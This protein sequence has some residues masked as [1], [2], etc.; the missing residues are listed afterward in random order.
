MMSEEEE[1]M[2]LEQ[3]WRQP[4]N[5]QQIRETITAATKYPNLIKQFAK[6]IAWSFS[7]K[8]GERHFEQKYSPLV[9]SI[10]LP[11]SDGIPFDIR[12]TTKLKDGKSWVVVKF[13]AGVEK[14]F[15]D[16]NS[17][18]NYIGGSAFWRGS[19]EFIQDFCEYY[20]NLANTQITVQNGT[21]NE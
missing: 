7:H 2:L 10:D 13:W 8:I 9:N 14:E 18:R 11:L 21:G 19:G 16:L 5:K 6:D 3:Q 1:K 15:F 12:I 17:F 20:T 4:T